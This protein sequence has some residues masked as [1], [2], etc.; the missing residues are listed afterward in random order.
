MDSH[1]EWKRPL[2]AAE[3]IEEI[4]N[5]DDDDV[6][7]DGIVI[8]PP[9]DFGY[10]TDCDSGDEECN[11]P[12]NLNYRQLAAEAEFYF[13]DDNIEAED[14]SGEDS[15]DNIPLATLAE[16]YWCSPQN[17]KYIKT[18]CIENTDLVKD[19]EQNSFHLPPPLLLGSESSP[20]QFFELMLT[21]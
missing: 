4:E 1:K 17:R 9:D 18:Q 11:N 15:D 7:P 6:V 10:N 20:L 2:T 8:M 19:A 21:P 12:D 16:R 13:K 5:I 3:L 14:S